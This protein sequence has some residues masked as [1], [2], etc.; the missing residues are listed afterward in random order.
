MSAAAAHIKRPALLRLGTRRSVL[1]I[2]WFNSSSYSTSQS[3]TIQS[4]KLLL[5]RSRCSCEKRT[6]CLLLSGLTVDKD[7]F[8]T[9]EAGLFS[10]ND[11]NKAPKLLK[12]EAPEQMDSRSYLKFFVVY[13]LSTSAEAFPDALFVTW[14]WR[15]GNKKTLTAGRNP[16]VALLPL[17]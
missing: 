10:S 6:R 7:S 16:A 14:R 12:K 8:E 15:G 9:S 2:L 13:L 5:M 1:E 4:Q 17:C 11:A 3:F